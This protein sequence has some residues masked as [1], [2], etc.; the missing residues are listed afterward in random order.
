MSFTILYWIYMLHE[1]AL[2][3]LFFAGIMR[4][5]GTSGRGVHKTV[6]ERAH[7]DETERAQA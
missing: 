1:V 5:L 7:K 6:E 3:D 2:F 4:L